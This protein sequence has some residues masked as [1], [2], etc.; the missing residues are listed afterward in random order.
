MATLTC[1]AESGGTLNRRWPQGW[2]L[3][4]PIDPASRRA[5][6]NT[7][8]PAAEAGFEDARCIDRIRDGD[9]EAARELVQRLYPTVIKIV[10]CR[11]PRRTLEEDRLTQ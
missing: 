2:L 11:L 10:R 7:P 1:A 8:A 3:D 5:V 9:D 6:A 4:W